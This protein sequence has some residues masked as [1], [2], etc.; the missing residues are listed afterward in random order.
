MI[1]YNN[2]F[3]PRIMTVIIHF[4]MSWQFLQMEWPEIC[5]ITSLIWLAGNPSLMK[6]KIIHQFDCWWWIQCDIHFVW[7]ESEYKNLVVM[8][9]WNALKDTE[10]GMAF[11][12]SQGN[13]N[14][15]RKK[16]V[17][18][19]AQRPK[20]IFPLKFF[21]SMVWAFPTEKV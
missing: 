19:T 13:D 9:I 6:F 1:T 18:V 10:I 5:W 20:K 2:V 14:S 15:C 7:R 12:N 11:S 3:T 8:K 17:K 21:D 4:K 16:R